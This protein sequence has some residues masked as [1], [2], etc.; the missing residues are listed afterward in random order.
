[1]TSPRLLRAAP[2]EPVLAVHAG[3]V[4]YADAWRW[5]RDLVPRR[6]RGDVGDVLLT[7]EHTKVFTAGSSAD[8]AH[9]LWDAA[10]RASRGVELFEVDRGGD[11]TYHGPGQ[12]V[13]YPVMQ[14]AGIRTVVSYVRALEEVCVRTAADFGVQARPVPGSTG[15]W[16][17][18]DK[19]VAIGVRVS[20]RGVTSHGLAFNVTTDLADFGG[21]VPCGIADRG[22]CSLRSLGVAADVADVVMRL[23]ARLAD[24]FGC[25]VVDASAEP[26]LLPDAAP[27]RSSA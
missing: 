13:A 23:R 2:E 9:V 25:V 26:G 19:L 24:V 27:A 10:E 6:A 5:Q 3:V 20:S 12:L 14:L 17:G 11:V 18:D 7:L 22:V 8:P 21:I 4:P 1:M 16:V 15:V